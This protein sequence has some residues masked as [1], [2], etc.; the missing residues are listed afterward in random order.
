LCFCLSNPPD[1]NIRFRY[2]PFSKSSTISAS[3]SWSPVKKSDDLTEYL[4]VSLIAVSSFELF[5]KDIV[6]MY[7]LTTHIKCMY[8]FKFSFNRLH[9]ITLHSFNCFIFL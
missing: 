9:Q 6:L 2:K 1:L 4:E 7:I 8:F 3:F 5:V